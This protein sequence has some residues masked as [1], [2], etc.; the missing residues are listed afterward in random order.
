LTLFGALLSFFLINCSI[1]SK[2]VIFD[3]KIGF[4]LQN[5]I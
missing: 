2:S 3:Y 1:T 4:F 5:L